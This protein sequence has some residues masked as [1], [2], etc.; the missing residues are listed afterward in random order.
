[1]CPIV[2]CG[3]SEQLDANVAALQEHKMA[4]AD[5]QLDLIMPNCKWWDR[6]Q[7]RNTCKLLGVLGKHFLR[8]LSTGKGSGQSFFSVS[9]RDCNVNLLW[10]QAGLRRTVWVNG[11]CPFEVAITFSDSAKV[12]EAPWRTQDVSSSSHSPRVCRAQ[13]PGSLSLSQGHFGRLS[14]HL[15]VSLWHFVSDTICL[16]CTSRVIMP[17]PINYSKS[18][19]LKGYTAV[20]RLQT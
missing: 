17:S 15:Y 12:C 5:G 14:F 6:C 7:I 2:A 10:A 4:P 8:E 18:L 1:M 20:L 19:I 11:W 13:T 16:S 9:Q 3:L